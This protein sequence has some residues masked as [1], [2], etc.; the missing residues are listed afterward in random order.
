LS[1]T[2]PYIVSNCWDDKFDEVWLHNH[3]EI[4]PSKDVDYAMVAKVY[5]LK[6]AEMFPE[7]SG[8]Y[9]LAKHLTPPGSAVV[10]SSF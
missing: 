5:N 3:K 1:F 6:I 9:T 2:R 8:T 10:R 7:V 4:K